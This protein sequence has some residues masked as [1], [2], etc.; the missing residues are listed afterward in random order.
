[1]YKYGATFFKLLHANINFLNSTSS[2]LSENKYLS[3][4]WHVNASVSVPHS[5]DTFQE[6][7]LQ[8]VHFQD[9]FSQHPISS[10]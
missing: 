6:R 3:V 5:T 10:R 8:Y 4:V 1:M 2:W 7:Y 9:A